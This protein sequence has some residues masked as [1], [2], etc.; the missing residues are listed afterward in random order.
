MDCTLQESQQMDRQS[1]AREFACEFSF[2]AWWAHQLS[3][4]LFAQCSC[5]CSQMAN[6]NLICFQQIFKRK[7]GAITK[8]K[9]VHFRK[10]GIYPKIYN[11]DKLN[12][13]NLTKEWCN[14]YGKNI[15]SCHWRFFKSVTF[16]DTSLLMHMS[17]YL[18]F[19]HSSIIEHV[20]SK[21]SL[22]SSKCIFE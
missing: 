1:Q 15:F 12:P 13:C 19:N 8:I 5:V 16:I 14:I 4:K 17:N 7:K 10:F 2:I 22:H 18:R 21:H 11:K 9:P 20:V 3:Q 6:T